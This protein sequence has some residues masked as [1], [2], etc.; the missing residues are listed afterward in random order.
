MAQHNTKT[1]AE[2]KDSWCTPPWLF[3][4]LRVAFLRPDGID[5]KGNTRGTSVYVF[6]P[7]RAGATCQRW[8]VMRDEMIKQYGQR[9]A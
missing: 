3:A 8:W 7:A 6:D 9:A 1:P 4:W 5:V 2:D